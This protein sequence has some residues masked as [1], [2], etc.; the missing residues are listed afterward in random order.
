MKGDEHSDGLLQWKIKM[1][2]DNFWPRPLVAVPM[3]L[4]QSVRSSDM[5]QGGSLLAYGLMMGTGLLQDMVIVTMCAWNVDLNG[6]SVSTLYIDILV[7]FQLGP[8]VEHLLPN[9]SVLSMVRSG[10]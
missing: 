5:A 3:S 4:G 7:C 9:I 1:K 6:P 8:W 2:I 10:F